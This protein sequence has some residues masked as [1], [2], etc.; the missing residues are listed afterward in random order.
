MSMSKKDY[1]AIA[2]AFKAQLAEDAQA[3]REAFRESRRESLAKVLNRMLPHLRASNPAFDADFFIEACG[4][5]LVKR[6]SA[7][8]DER[9]ALSA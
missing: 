5:E 1:V 6:P 4:F 2:A 9:F 3:H 7:L 8:Y